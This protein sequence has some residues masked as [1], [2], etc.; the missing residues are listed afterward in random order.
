MDEDRPLMT[1]IPRPRGWLG[2]LNLTCP[3]EQSLQ[4]A[5][6]GL[7]A[8]WLLLGVVLPLAPLV[9]RSLSDAEGRWVGLAN[10][11]RYFQTPGLA[12]S[13]GN[14]LRVAAVST[15]LAVTLAFGYAYALTR[16]AM[17]AKGFFRAVAM[18]PLYAPT[19]ALGIGLVYLFGNKG[20]VTTGFLGLGERLFGRPVGWD[21]H[22]YGATG[23]V[24][25]E[26][27]Y[28]FPQALVILVVAA[29]LADA[30]LYEASQALRA[31]S[32]RTFWTVTLPTLRYGLVSAFFVCFTLA[33]TDFGVAKVVGGNFNVLATDIYKQVIGQQNFSMG[34]A[35]SILLLTPTVIAFILDRWVQRQQ[36]ATLTTRSVPYQPKPSPG[37]DLLA[38]LYCSLIATAVLLVIGAV[39]LAAV[40]NIWPYNLQLTL[41]HFDFRAVGGGGAAAFWNSLR[42]S[43]YTAVVGAALTFASAYLVEKSRGLRPLRAS[44]YFFSMIPV[45]L[46]GL[47]IGLAYIFFFNP[48]QWQIAGLSVPNPFS[49]LYGTM[50]ILVLANIVHFYTV[51]FMTATT[52][53]KQLDAEF[54]AVS[55]S[56]R[57]PFYRTFWRIT[58]PLCL[59]A[60][61]EIAIYYFVNAMVTVSAVIFLYSP[62]L[63]LAAV[64]IVNMDD[65]GDTAAAAA[66]S[67]LVILTSVGARLL[68]EVAVRQLNQR[69]QR[70]RAR[71]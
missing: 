8:L 32:L 47:V 59:P 20:L 14:S 2:Q 43:L 9:S 5:L 46:P 53:L 31:T 52:A 49:F 61:L 19:L 50:G 48:R 35:I 51:S 36:A 67:A 1:T 44:I 24:L 30:R 25:G 28:C 60:I 27:L 55:A 26:S 69:T 57:V 33:F 62:T 29:S 68:Y 7:A 58:A 70:W 22:L 56:L 54:E 63:K 6:I 13:F 18:L 41:R 65:A 23:I 12:Q 16:T 34:A 42:M 17:P 4:Q 45:A 3:G 21:I 37:V 39:F 64:A 38:T 40:V 10:F 15:V 11:V 71:E 66:M